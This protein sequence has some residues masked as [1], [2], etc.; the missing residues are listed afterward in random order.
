MSL[1]N[2]HLL[3]NIY[4]GLSSPDTSMPNSPCLSVHDQMLFGFDNDEPQPPTSCMDG[5][6]LNDH[7]DPMTANASKPIAFRSPLS[8]FHSRQPS[9]SGFS[10][11]FRGP[12]MHRLSSGSIALFGNSYTDSLSRTKGGELPVLEH[13]LSTDGARTLS[14]AFDENYIYAGTQSETNEITVYNRKYLQQTAQLAGHTGS[15]LALLYVPERKWLFSG[16]SDGTVRLWDTA[17]LTFLSE[18]TP[19]YD[20]SGDI[21]S[22]AWDPRSGGTLYFGAQ[23]TDIEYINFGDSARFSSVPEHG[24]KEILI[25]EPGKDV[26]IPQE[27]PIA[28]TLRSSRIRP[29]SFFNSRPCSPDLV[30]S[31]AVSAKAFPFAKPASRPTTPRTLSLPEK[32]IVPHDNVVSSAH[33]G[34]IYCMNLFKRADDVIWLA[35]GSGDS[36]VKVWECQPKGGL[37]FLFTFDGLSG[38]VLSL[39]VRD[40][41]LFVGLQDGHIKVWD[42]ETKACIR[43]I[44]AHNSDVLAM[45]LVGTDLYTASAEGQILRFDASFDCT[46][47]FQAHSGAILS[48]VIMPT[49]EDRFELITAGH[50]SYVK[51]WRLTRPNSVNAGPSS[52][53]L[54]GADGDVMLYAL[55]KMI[56]IPSVSDQAHREDCRQSAHLLRKI[57]TQMG[58]QASLLPTIEGKNPIVMAKF[59]GQ[60]ASPLSRKRVLFYG[61][62]DVQP[63]TEAD[64]TTDPWELSGRNGYLY[65]RGVADNKGPIMAVAC[66][67]ASLQERRLLDV[68]LTMIIEGEEE[69]GSAGFVQALTRFKDDIGHI[70]TILLSNSSWIGEDDPCVVFGLRGV[71]YANFSIASQNNDL[72]SGVDGG[73]VAEPMLAMVQLLGSIGSGTQVQIPGFYDDVAE[74]T[75]AEKEYYQAVSEVTGMDT[76]NVMRKWRAP[77]FSVSNIQSSGPANNTIIP[78]SVTANVSFRLVPNQSIQQIAQSI[79]EHCEKTF[80][81]FAGEMSLKVTITHQADWWL[82]SVENPYF[83]A[84]E[85]AVEKIWGAKPLRIREGGSIPTIPFLEDLFNAPCVHL[86]LGQHSTAAHL[87]NE[88]LRLLN[89]RNGKRV[90]EE[91]LSSL[92]SI[93]NA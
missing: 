54:F 40:D 78:R 61:H 45:S 4:D 14:L 92:S 39:V 16:S 30:K 12:P 32:I 34:Y 26:H 75:A 59:K 13:L 21:Y 36:D 38:A 10:P 22:L 50:D 18:I 63:A 83:K 51:L 81:S 25:I 85:R 86:P 24:T 74:L 90:I 28:K 15:V 47:T 23:N 77:T 41:L 73:S 62:Y 87:S 1:T 70:D 57:L 55:A 7:P 8:P 53:V 42:L 33:Y 64:W 20:T 67:A 66:A 56:A 72:H 76:E 6:V 65:G 89:L 11:G 5:M 58:A 69:S 17:N 84:L 29:H 82:A 60:A 43:T 31:P 44:L 71:I 2:I 68:D 91:F 3:T 46:A 9:F 35:S 93:D 37:K 19:S 49:H 48:T 80:A 88:R 27:P 52:D 79:T